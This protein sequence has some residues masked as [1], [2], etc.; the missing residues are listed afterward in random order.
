[1][2]C[3]VSVM[4]LPARPLRLLASHSAAMTRMARTVF[5]AG[6]ASIAMIAAAQAQA[7]KPA[8]GETA[9]ALLENDQVRVREMRFKPGAKTPASA[10]PSSFAYALTDGAL[11]FAPPGRT[12]YELTFKAGE[13]LWLPQSTAAANET[14]REIRVL[15]VEIKGRAPSVKRGKAKTGSRKARHGRQG[16]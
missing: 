8:N 3:R 10:H 14:N 12:P 16:R 11:V 9:T 7:A 1:M 15:V 2:W 13:A 6:C 4:S 5:L